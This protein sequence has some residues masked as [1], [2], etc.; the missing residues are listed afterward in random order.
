MALKP[1]KQGK[2]AI[3]VECKTALPSICTCW[4]LRS[5]PHQQT[6]QLPAYAEVTACHEAIVA[7]QQEKENLAV[8]VHCDLNQ[9]FRLKLTVQI[10]LRGECSP[11]R[12]MLSTPLSGSAFPLSQ[13]LPAALGTGFRTPFPPPSSFLQRQLNGHAHASLLLLTLSCLAAIP[14]RPASV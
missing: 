7:K 8:K 2:G 1:N 11:A 5:V 3:G 4:L 9:C 12:R 6:S 13:Q 10:Q 14:R